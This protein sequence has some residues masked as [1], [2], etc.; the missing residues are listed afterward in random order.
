MSARHA[1]DLLLRRSAHSIVVVVELARI[2]DGG[3]DMETESGPACVLQREGNLSWRGP[4]FAEFSL[5]IR[6]YL[7][8]VIYII[9][10]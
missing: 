9:V 6:K 8:F 2:V 7:R 4:R 3:S 5:L 1:I 10:I